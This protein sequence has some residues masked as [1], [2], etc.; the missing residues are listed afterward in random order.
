VALGQPGHRRLGQGVHRALERGQR[1]RAGR[2]VGQPAQFGLGGVHGG[3]DLPGPA[4]QQHP[5]RGQPHPAAGAF[6][7][8]GAG[9]P[10][11]R[12]ELLGDRGRAEVAALGDRPDG[13]VGGQVG[14][15]PQSPGVERHPHCCAAQLNSSRKC[16]MDVTLGGS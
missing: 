15:Q 14:Q 10:L 4:G 1:D 8:R 7:Q 5:G 3:Q 6:Q 9:L 12:G 13:A 16:E 11:Q 2:L